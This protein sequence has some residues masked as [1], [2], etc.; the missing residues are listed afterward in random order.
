MYSRYDS[1]IDCDVFATLA[2]SRHIAKMTHRIFDLEQFLPFRLAVTAANVSRDFSKNYVANYGLDAAEWRIICLLSTLD[3]GEV[4]S[5]RDL[6]NRVH[7]EKSKISRAVTRLTERN[8]LTKS[9]HRHD[10]RLLQ[11]ALTDEGKRVFTQ[12]SPIAYEYE[13]KLVSN[14]TKQEH[15]Q[16]MKILEK[17]SRNHA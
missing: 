11:I 1:P 15:A 9:P 17:L 12:V 2:V 3:D 13:S 7:L 6:E 5:V 16:F 14:L 8:L 10:A 4:I